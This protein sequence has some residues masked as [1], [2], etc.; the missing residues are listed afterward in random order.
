[1]ISDD[2]LE[3]ITKYINVDS[4]PSETT[5]KRTRAEID[6]EIRRKYEISDLVDGALDSSTQSLI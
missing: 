6:E 5:I 1:M 3:S 2:L 4:L